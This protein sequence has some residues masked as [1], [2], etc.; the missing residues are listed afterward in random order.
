MP[1]KSDE[2]IEQLTALI[3]QNEI[4]SGSEITQNELSQSLGI[5]RIPVREVLIILEY[6]GLIEKL[7]NQHVRVAAINL[8]YFQEIFSI[9]AEI[10][11][12]ILEKN[13]EDFDFCDEMSFHRN[14][15]RLSENTFIKKMLDSILRIFISFVLNDSRRSDMTEYLQKIIIDIKSGRKD[16]VKE[17]LFLYFNGLAESAWNI[18][19]R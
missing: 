15:I 13:F 16:T 2:V 3:L 8:S 18:R 5:S 9:A 14:I 1:R 17:N 4:K 6:I 19:N 11:L 10:E 7:P 12:R